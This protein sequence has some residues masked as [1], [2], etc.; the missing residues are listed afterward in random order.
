MRSLYYHS[1][2]I[3]ALM[4]LG[5][6]GLGLAAGI[7]ALVQ[8]GSF[9]LGFWCFFLVQALFVAIPN[10]MQRNSKEPEWGSDDAFHRAHRTAEAALRRLSAGN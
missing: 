5:L 6:S 3:P 2:V 4:D 7:W 8:S 10:S 1:S 9:F